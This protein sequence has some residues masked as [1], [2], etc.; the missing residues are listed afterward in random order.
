MV[1]L[2]T[3]TSRLVASLAGMATTIALTTTSHGSL[4][5][6][7]D[8]QNGGT[9]ATETGNAAAPDSTGAAAIWNNP[10]AAGGTITTLPFNLYASDDPGLTSVAAQ[11]VTLTSDGNNND[12]SNTVIGS[13]AFDPAGNN[14]VAGFQNLLMEDYVFTSTLQTIVF[15]NLMPGT[16]DVYAYGVGDV[17][18]A[19]VFGLGVAEGSFPDLASARAAGSALLATTPSPSGYILGE[20]YV[21]LSDIAVGLDGDMTL[22][23][24]NANDGTSLGVLGGLQLVQTSVIPEPASAALLAMG[25]ALVARR[26]R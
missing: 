26:R 17:S 21:L 13:G 3:H 15:D 24:Y 25:G 16:Y 23:Y 14:V 11:L 5:I 19:G 6:N 8:I 10:A 4:V 22:T 12:G 9:S 1:S 7:I 18:T 2:C 20:H